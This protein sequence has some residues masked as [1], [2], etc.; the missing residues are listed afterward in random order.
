MAPIVPLKWLE[1]VDEEN[2][3]VTWGI[4][5]KEGE[6]RDANSLDLRTGTGKPVPMSSWVTASW[7]DGSIKWTAHGA[8]LNGKE[9]YAVAGGT[10]EAAGGI[11]LSEDGHEI[12][13]STNRLSCRIPK[14]GPLFIR[15]LKPH[16]KERGMN[17]VVNCKIRFSG[18]EEEGGRETLIRETCKSSVASSVVEHSSSHR[19]CVRTEGGLSLSDASVPFLFILRLYFYSNGDDV[20]LVFTVVCDHDQE[21]H[22]LAG[23]SLDFSLPLF[24]ELHNRHIAFAGDEGLF[25]E[26]CRILLSHR[27]QGEVFQKEQALLRPVKVAALNEDAKTE[28]FAKNLH[29]AALWKNFKLDQ[30]G[31]DS[32]QISKRTEKG[33]SRVW[34]VSGKR[35]GGM[36]YLAGEDGGAAFSV[37]DFWQKF[38]GSLE[39]DALDED[40]GRVR[41]WLWSDE[42]QPFNFRLYDTRGHGLDFAYEGDGLPENSSKGIANTSEACIRLYDT[43]PSRE[44]LWA[45]AQNARKNA[46]LVCSPER[47]HESRA[48]GVWALPDTSR[49]GFEKMDGLVSDI[50]SFYMR[51]IEQRRWYGFWNYGD[52]MHSYDPIRHVWRYDLG[53]CAWHNTELAVPM[54]LWH[55]FLRSGDPKT[56]EFARIMCRHTAEVDCYHLEPYKGMGIRHNVVHWGCNAKETRVTQAFYHRPF[57]YLT[58]DERTGENMDAVKDADRAAFLKDP[59]GMYFGGRHPGYIHA[60]SGPDWL[61]WASNWMSQYERFRDEEYW[62]KLHKG[63]KSLED[64]P[65]GLLA[66]PTFLYN[67]DDGRLLP[68]SDNNYHYHMVVAFGGSE[69]LLEL[70]R[71]LPGDKKLKEMIAQFGKGYTMND[72]EIKAFTQGRLTDKHEMSQKVYAAHLIAYAARHY[73]DPTLGARAWELIIEEMK[74]IS[75]HNKLNVVKVHSLDYPVPVEEVPGLSTNNAA[76]ISLAYYAAAELIPEYMPENL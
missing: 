63:L 54:W 33:C 55:Q 18:G 65:I 61:A 14:K 49:L 1:N 64:D 15:D 9:T 8:V 48:L 22:E 16:G 29:H 7:P 72:E 58:A 6:L 24:G 52:V 30:T 47:Y 36:I 62:Q 25:T 5:W 12:S 42:A 43:P 57:Y 74:K 32:F 39:A 13:V 75:L 46:L 66:G 44:R 68:M 35:A 67:P 40:H 38:P 69:V 23:L 17:G 27:S 76:Q 50:V 28:W 41:L 60:R 34:A 11:K 53:G 10:G 20:R 2:L 3:G 45:F 21:K 26:A 59:M 19:V 71:W 70:E 73:K 56:F 37:R 51:Q 31:P 4:P